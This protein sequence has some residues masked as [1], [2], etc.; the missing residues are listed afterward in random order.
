[1][2]SLWG[3]NLSN[4]YLWQANWLVIKE[5]KKDHSSAKYLMNL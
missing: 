4:A 3:I 2:Q 1:M 5:K